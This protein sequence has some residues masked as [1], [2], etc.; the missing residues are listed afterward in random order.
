M[1]FD[2]RFPQEQQQTQVKR[3]REQ[4]NARKCLSTKCEFFWRS[5]LYERI[6]ASICDE[7]EA[8]QRVYVRIHSK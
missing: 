7:D 8:H 1:P 5:V 4:T 3:I 6:V 2:A